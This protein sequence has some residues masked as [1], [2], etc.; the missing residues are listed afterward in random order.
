MAWLVSIVS[1]LS[2]GCEITPCSASAP[3]DC[4]AGNVLRGDWP[5]LAKIRVRK[6]LRKRK[7]D[8]GRAQE[9]ETP[10][11]LHCVG[12]HASCLGCESAALT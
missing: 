8:Y 5:T 3:T 7:A 9:G 11:R 2:V 10:N 6:R 4:L 1:I 12:L